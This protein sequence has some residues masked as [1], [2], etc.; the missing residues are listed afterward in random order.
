MASEKK[1][2]TGFNKLALAATLIA[3]A[4][5][6][7][8]AGT[9]IATA[10]LVGASTATITAV[11][12]AINMVIAAVITKAFFTPN[13]P[14]GGGAGGLSG[15]SPNPGN[16]Q[17]IPPAT[18][19]KLPVV[20]GEAWVGGTIVDLSISQ[21]N[22]E[23]Y[24]VIAISEVTNNGSDT[25]TFGD[26]YYGGKKCIFEANTAT[27]NSLGLV[28]TVSGN[29]IY[30]NNINSIP[31]NG[32]QITFANSGTPTVY[33]IS[34]VSAGEQNDAT[35]TF[36]TTLVG[37]SAGNTIYSYLYNGDA[38]AIVRGLLDESTG[39]T[40]NAVDNKLKIYL[41][42]NGSNSPANCLST[43]I[44]IMQT[45]G[46]V[47]QWNETKLMTN[48]AFA[49][50]H[51]TYDSN[52]G[53][54]GIQQTKFQLENSRYEP[55]DCFYDYLTNTVYGAAIPDSQIDTAS[56]T[57]LDVYCAGSFSYT[58]SND[59]PATQA[60][61]TFDGVLD[62]TR[63]I[64]DN[65]QSMA[66]SC[67]CLIK[68][69]EIQGKWG[70]ITQ[71][72]VYTI[73]LNL[74][75]SN[76]VST[77]QI[78]PLDIAGSYNVVE[79]KFPDNSNQDAFN[80]STFDLAQ[81]DPSLLYPNEPV[82][83]QSVS[84]PLVNNDVRAQYIATRMLKASREDLQV[85]V[86]INFQGI[87]LEAGDIVTITNANYGWTLKE[88]R[89]MKITE[90][91]ESNGA[92]TAKLILTEFTA[93]IYDDAPITQFQPS[94]NTGIPNPIVFGTVP[95]PVVGASY[96]TNANPLFLV[97]ITASSA[98]IIQ[99][100]ELWYSAFS[101]PME[102]QLFFAGTTAVQS[103]GTPYNPGAALP[104]ISVS[105]IPAGT[106]FF[107]S[108]MVNSLGTSQFSLA[109]AAFVWKPT[110]FQYAERYLAVAYANNATGTSGFSLSPTNRSYYGLLNTPA[111]SGTFTPN[112][113]TWYLA[114]PDFGTNKFVCYANRTGRKFSFATGFANYASGTGAFVPTQ[115]IIFDPRLW[116]ALPNGENFIDL[117]FGTGQV[118]QTGTTTVGTGEI[119]VTNNP[120]GKVIASLKQYLD[121][122]SGIYQKTST[123]AQ[124]T[125]DIYGRVVGFEEPDAFYITIQSF[126][127]TSGQT[128]FTVTRGS[129]YISGQCLVFQNGIL[130]D[131]ASYTD[132]GGAT[133]T[134]TF[135]TGRT[136]G[137]GITIISFKSVTGLN[138]ITNAASGNGTTATL[139][140]ATRA[141][142]P[143][144]VGQSITVSGVMPSGYNGTY[145]VTGCTTS[146]V[147]YANATTG[148]QTVAGTIVF[149]NPVYPS[150]TRN[151][152]TLTN[153]SSF[154][155]SG[156]SITSGYEFMFLNG[157]VLTEQ[158]YDIVGGTI[159]NL[160]SIANGLLTVIQW[161]ENN[162]TTPNGDPVNV[163]I[164]TIIGQVSYPFNYTTGGFNLYQNGVLLL[165]GTD[166]TTASG[167]YVLTNSPTTN[168]DLL[169][170]QTF[171]RTGA[172]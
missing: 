116:S 27:Y 93:S 124:L 62:T 24:Y 74:N 158:D 70:V 100:A 131:A 43:A 40:D 12:F 138:L 13:Q 105:N 140:F 78:T 15:D 126:T 129:G 128:V 133:G 166:Y 64:M 152:A 73:A 2:K 22:Q 8:A 163:L 57:A 159:T 72:P 154:T 99:Y 112:E 4:A 155:P 38:T 160:P 28:T 11:A 61:F 82:N 83:K 165:N 5:P 86:T 58:D 114:D 139:T 44:S 51:I 137:V 1:M 161:S 102:S 142:A 127:A 147:S 149:T 144:T 60:R 19:N 47:Y 81:I 23:L 79:C 120:D 76:M 171:A 21:N 69:N 162:L 20:Y 49:I 115:A 91:F 10:I 75:D 157:A 95:T 125:I 53:L 172:V 119:E 106:W 84:L 77:I 14:S 98:G 63:S 110:T 169:L 121:F 109:S 101:N 108:R 89:V 117:D 123:V 132:T 153:A 107:F 168:T 104:A 59:D 36:T 94:T 54:T 41:Y 16:R 48:T 56:L 146:T 136:L 167:G 17:Q 32:T 66:S 135:G 37:V 55:G 31:A 6:S 90:D 134:V 50:V 9:I 85:Q 130:Q 30:T 18:D 80:S 35:I 29:Q 68:Y 143:F 71:T 33:T 97:N 111:A 42:N 156:F 141:V 39:T 170:Q 148:S 151:T 26:V 25:I 88:F 164:N 67:D 145:T 118:L 92:V 65:L 87:Q 7:Y 45:S 103:N 46:L 3:F 122:G 113:Y 52:A 34:S 96:P 150:F